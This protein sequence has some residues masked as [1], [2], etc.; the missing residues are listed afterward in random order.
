MYKVNQDT[1]SF[2]NSFY[3]GQT[4]DVVSKYYQRDSGDG[5]SFPFFSTKT[6]KESGEVIVK[7]YHKTEYYCSKE[8]GDEWY[9]ITNIDVSPDINEPQCVAIKGNEVELF[10]NTPTLDIMY[11]IAGY[12]SLTPPL[13]KTSDFDTDDIKWRHCRRG[14]VATS[15]EIR[16]SKLCSI[17]F[18]N[19]LP[20][21]YKTYKYEAT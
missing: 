8:G 16:N 17:K 11:K 3:Q 4:N 15:P 20:T 19:K 6:N 10:F 21:M 5:T 18:V 14:E 1:Y 2:D 13:D 9:D 12:Y 7:T